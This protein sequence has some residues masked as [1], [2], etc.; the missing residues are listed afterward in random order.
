MEGTM[1]WSMVSATVA[2][3]Q[4]PAVLSGCVVGL[5]VGPVYLG[6]GTTAVYVKTRH[7]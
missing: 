2:G 6:N 7:D 5:P 4:R 1:A 3:H